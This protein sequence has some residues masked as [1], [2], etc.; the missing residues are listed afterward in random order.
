MLDY[1]ENSSPEGFDYAKELHLNP[2][3]EKLLLYGLNNHHLIRGRVWFILTGGAQLQKFHNKDYYQKLISESKQGIFLNSLEEEQIQKDVPRTNL[4]GVSMFL[5]DDSKETLERILAA[6]C[7]RSPESVGYCQSMNLLAGTLLSLMTEEQAFYSLCCIVE[8]RLGY[9]SSS[10]CMI[11]VDQLVL[12]D[13]VQFHEPEIHQH[14]SS[15]GISVAE[16]CVGW[17]LCLFMESPLPYHDCIL[18]WDFLFYYGDGLLFEIT[19]AL[20]KLQKHKILDMNTSEELLL[21]FVRKEKILKNISI[22]QLLEAT[23]KGSLL[24]Q[25]SMLRSFYQARV[26]KELG[27][28]ELAKCQQIAKDFSIQ[29]EKYVL[30]Y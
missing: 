11:H 4:E 13:I 24:P 19:L 5:N 29:E 16:F 3:S 7:V 15:V 8:K 14:L 1:V 23:T 10:M 21:F 26:L 18:L 28:M 20:M 30:Q 9:Y 6:Y 27:S 12:T 22:R 2:Y 17:F 25:V